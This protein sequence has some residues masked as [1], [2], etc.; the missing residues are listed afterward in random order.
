MCAAVREIFETDPIQSSRGG[1]SMPG[2]RGLAEL[3]VIV[4]GIPPGIFYTKRLVEGLQIGERVRRLVAPAEKEAKANGA[5]LLID[6]GDGK[7][8]PLEQAHRAKVLEA[9]T[10]LQEKRPKS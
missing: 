8:I 2:T 4:V 10:A 9:L 3:A 1:G 7:P 6:C 5:R